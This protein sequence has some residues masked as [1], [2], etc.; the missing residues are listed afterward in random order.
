MAEDDHAHEPRPARC[1]F[2]RHSCGVPPLR[3]GIDD[4]DRIASVAHMAGDQPAPQRRL[5]GAQLVAELLVNLAAITWVYEEQIKIGH[6]K[7][8]HRG[9]PH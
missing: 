5:D 4:L 2:R 1:C 9:W 7:L 6:A 8:P 3:L